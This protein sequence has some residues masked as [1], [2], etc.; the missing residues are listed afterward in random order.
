MNEWM[1][2]SCDALKNIMEKT[3]GIEYWLALRFKHHLRTCIL[4]LFFVSLSWTSKQLQLLKPQFSHGTDVVCG[5]W[6]LPQRK[7]L[8]S[9]AGRT[10]RATLPEVM[11]CPKSPTPTEWRWDMKVLAC[12]ANEQLWSQRS[13]WGQLSCHQAG[14]TAHH[15]HP[16]PTPLPHHRP[17]LLPS[18]PAT[19][20][21][22]KGT[23]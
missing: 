16:A 3:A 21:N 7:D 18:F 22:P 11:L 13:L 1:T 8:L 12:L 2:S 14:I 20:V 23:P 5:I 4:A 15:L 17:C 6:V 9:P 10:F 19:S